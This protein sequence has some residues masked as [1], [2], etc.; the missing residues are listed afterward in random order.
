VPAGGFSSNSR[1][2]LV[3]VLADNCGLSEYF[4]EYLPVLNNYLPNLCHNEDNR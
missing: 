1:D 2:F 3:I 4:T